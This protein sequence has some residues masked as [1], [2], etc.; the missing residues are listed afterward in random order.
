MP[1]E[2]AAVLGLIVLPFLIFAAALAYA[3]Y[4]VE[5]QHKNGEKP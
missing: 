2:I 3:D 5:H 4:R 1:L